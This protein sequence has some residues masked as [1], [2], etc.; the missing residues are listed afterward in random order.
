MIEKLM[1]QLEEKNMDVLEYQG[2]VSELQKENDDLKNDFY[3]KELTFNESQLKTSQEVLG[4]KSELKGLKVENKKLEASVEELK[5][6]LEKV[7]SDI[8]DKDESIRRLEEEKQLMNAF[9]REKLEGQDLDQLLKVRQHLD[10]MADHNRGLEAQLASTKKYYE[11]IVENMKTV[12]DMF[13]KN[14]SSSNK[15]MWTH[16]DN[17]NKQLEERTRM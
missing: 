13:N 15:S 17:L 8:Y 6:S 3:I 16:V 11:E 1:D 5:K 2:L 7:K 10:E 9:V 12:L 4:L 14:K